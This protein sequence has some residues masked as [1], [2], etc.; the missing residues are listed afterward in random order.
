M[1]RMFGNRIPLAI[2]ITAVLLTT[3]C[4]GVSLGSAVDNVHRTFQVEPGGK[5]TIDSDTGSIEVSAGGVNEVRVDIEREASGTTDRE[6]AEIL[7]RLQVDTQQNGN[8]IYIRARRPGDGFFSFRGRRLRL[9]FVVMVP[10]KF[11][12]DL[13]TGGGS[14]GVKDLEGTVMA[15]TSGGSLKFGHI[16]GPVTGHTSGGSIQLEGGQG[17]LDVQTSGGSI[18]IG[19]VNGPVKAHTS[20]G[21]IH[22]EEVQGSIEAST[23]GGGISATIGM[24]P[25][26]DCELSTSGGSIRA[27]LSRDLNLDVSAKTSGGSVR[28]D[29]PI[30]IQGERTRSRL[31]G[32]LNQGGP[33]LL[34]ATSGGGISIDALK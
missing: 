10:D 15:R 3:A 7:S 26:G 33:R 30:G 27:W 8:D 31:E 29:L 12:L 22:V 25:E 17:P 11:N 9:R 21:S 24:Q 5:L 28:T 19:R 1:K 16:R 18:H 13:K 20:G 4:Y 14:I 32:R 6:S 2:L 34:L 23:S